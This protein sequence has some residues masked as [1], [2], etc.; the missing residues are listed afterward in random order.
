MGSGRFLVASMKGSSQCYYTNDSC[1][2]GH[3]Q[4]TR[5]HSRPSSSAPSLELTMM[6]NVSWTLHYWPWDDR[7]SPIQWAFSAPYVSADAALF[8]SGLLYDAI[9]WSDS[10]FVFLAE[11]KGERYF[12]RTAPQFSEIAASSYSSFAW[13]TRCASSPSP[14]FFF[15][16]HLA[17]TLSS[18]C[19]L[20]FTSHRSRSNW[21]PI[22][23]SP[24]LLLFLS[25]NWVLRWAKLLPSYAFSI[26]CCF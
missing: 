1:Y 19:L 10:A 25:W 9:I 22:E 15:W 7:T 20:D 26:R 2:C 16:S 4:C 11:S 3:S 24:M 17:C 5:D 8:R 14:L 23:P 13:P 18:C 12:L 21:F 6:V